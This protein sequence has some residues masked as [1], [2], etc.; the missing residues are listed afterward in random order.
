MALKWLFFLKN[1]KKSPSSWVL[2]SQTSV[3]D[4]RKLHHAICLARYLIKT[5]LLQ[6]ISRKKT[7]LSLIMDAR[8]T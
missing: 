1:H 8:L 6:K 3:C 5:F 2:R 4:T 7:L